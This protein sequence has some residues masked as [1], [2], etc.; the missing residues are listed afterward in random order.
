MD[1]IEDGILA[2]ITAWV[3]CDHLPTATN[4][5]LVDIAA[6]PDILMALRDRNRV[7]VGVIAHQRLRADLAVG[8][9]AGL[10]WRN[11]QW[12]H[13]GQIALQPIADRF[14]VTA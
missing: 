3:L 1:G 8:L 12:L 11:R 4:H 9:V 7:I 5:D 6:D 2:R 10:E 13:R 14:L